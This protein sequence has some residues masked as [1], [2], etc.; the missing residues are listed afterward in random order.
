M[1]FSIRAP[2]AA[3]L[4]LAAAGAALSLGLPARAH[5]LLD[6]NALQPTPLN[7]LVSGL[8]HPVIGPDHLLFLLALSL[9]GLQ[10][11]GLWMLTLLAVGML[12]SLAGLLAPGLPGAELI[13]AGTL[14]VVALVLWR[15]LPTTVLLPCMGVH[16]YVLS[17][18]VLGWTAMPIGFYA[19][20]LLLSQ[21]ALLVFALALLRRLTAR[22][23]ARG[24][25]WSGLL[26]VGASAS[27]ALSN[28]VS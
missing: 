15:W 1:S 17:G 3:G 23:P 26:L 19:A 4:P 14:A 25:R 22:I 28:A 12:G 21:A 11:R 16:G 8:L 9:V 2:W 10:R 5:H 7:G 27:L 24:L 6:V 13:V 18:S 20:G